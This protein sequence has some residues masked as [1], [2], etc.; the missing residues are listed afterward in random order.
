MFTT[1]KST[2][3]SKCQIQSCCRG[4][5]DYNKPATAS[6]KVLSKRDFGELSCTQFISITISCCLKVLPVAVYSLSHSKYLWIIYNWLNLQYWNMSVFQ[7]KIRLSSSLSL[8]AL[9]VIRCC[10]Q[11]LF[12]PHF[13]QF[14]S[15]FSNTGYLTAAW[16]GCSLLVRLL[17]SAKPIISAR[18]FAVCMQPRTLWC[19]CEPAPHHL[20][21]IKPAWN[22]M[23]MA[24]PQPAAT[25][26]L[27]PAAHG[28]LLSFLSV[29]PPPGCTCLPCGWGC[30]C[31][32]ISLWI[33]I[34]LWIYLLI[35]LIMQHHFS[36]NLA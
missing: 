16:L 10:C 15:G 22:E 3:R 25:K 31:E 4:T 30:V 36:F 11:F 28:E 7:P 20:G 26:R 9:P 1:V 5:V 2:V 23:L 14:A 12:P 35:S 24:W 13:T 18:V 29:L 34:N 21:C 32:T 17:S 8:K 6:T 33:A 19:L 27:L